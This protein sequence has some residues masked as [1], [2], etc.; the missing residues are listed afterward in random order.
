MATTP[1][2]R[3][4]RVRVLHAGL[5]TMHNRRADGDRR[6]Q[7]QAAQR[8]T[9]QES[10]ARNRPDGKCQVHA[11]CSMVGVRCTHRTANLEST[12]KTARE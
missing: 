8:E 7:G 12:A 5:H 2:A 1:I 6:D 11:A 4:V 9:N 10:T 3:I